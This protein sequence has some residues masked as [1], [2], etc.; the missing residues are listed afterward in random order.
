[1]NKLAIDIKDGYAVIAAGGDFEPEFIK[2]DFKESDFIG[3]SENDDSDMPGLFDLGGEHAI[4]LY[5]EADEITLIVPMRFSLVKPV[6]ISQAAIKTYGDEFLKWEA[7][8]QLP[9]ELGRFTFGFNKLAESYDSKVIKYMY[10]AVP[11]D[12]IEVLKDFAAPDS[13]KKISLDSEAMGQF[14]MINHITNSSSFC[15][16]ISLEH[17]GASIVISNNGDFLSGRFIGRE[18][19]NLAD[20]IAFYIMGHASEGIT[21][22]A[23]ICGDLNQLD[24]IGKISWA[25]MLN[26]PESISKIKKPELVPTGVFA[27]V[28][29]LLM[30]K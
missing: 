5:D 16:A 23:L 1:M 4:K 26:V 28:A 15:T 22:Q 29:G 27:A 14:N 12:F 11:S 17:D 21:P 7:F 19:S 18:K 3:N 2:I 25:E 6:S 8:Q 10:Y 24:A 13:A 9:E 20:E 30:S